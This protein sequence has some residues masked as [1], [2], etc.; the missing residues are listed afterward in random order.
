[1]FDLIKDLLDPNGDDQQKKAHAG[2][3]PPDAAGLA[4]VRALIERGQTHDAYEVYQQ[5]T[6]GSLHD[7]IT[8]V[9]ALEAE[10][11]ITR[12]DIRWGSEWLPATCPHCGA[13]LTPDHVEWL[14]EWAQSVRCPACKTILRDA[15]SAE[16]EAEDA[17]TG[18]QAATPAAAPPQFV[19][20]APTAIGAY[21]PTQ[22]A[23]CGG[24]GRHFTAI[25]PAC[26]GQGSALVWQP[27]RPCV[28]CGGDGQDFATPCGQCRGTGWE[29]AIVLSRVPALPKEIQFV[30]EACAYCRGSGRHFTQ[31]CPAC[32][33]KGGVA[34]AYPSRPCGNCR[35]SGSYFTALC[36]ACTGSGWAHHVAL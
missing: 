29:R 10:M 20:V 33:G 5:N 7:A 22:C 13:A 3:P 34:A 27:A 30:R 14:D 28:K 9:N 26:E 16:E 8:Y 18:V 6:G 4:K 36:S 2:P 24:S 15:S 31:T 19:S 1:M 32:G 25:C 17:P 35:G 21:A 12:P 11:L 23:T